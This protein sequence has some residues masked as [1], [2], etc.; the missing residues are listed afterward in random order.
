MHSGTF[1]WEASLRSPY[2][3]GD[4][5]S[6]PR[7]SGS[8][9][10]GRS[11]IIEPSVRA[12]ELDSA[13]RQRDGGWDDGFTTTTTLITAIGMIKTRRNPDNERGVPH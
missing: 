4:W 9:L 3:D 7:S 5:S 11:Q 6:T 1:D 10:K 12:W 8:I 2:Y 13:A